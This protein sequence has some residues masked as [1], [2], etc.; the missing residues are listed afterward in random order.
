MLEEHLLTV[1]KDAAPEGLALGY[2]RTSQRERQARATTDAC[3]VLAR[4][5][6]SQ[7][8]DINQNLEDS[9]AL[10]EERSSERRPR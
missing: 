10:V 4:G 9:Q 3:R 6:T 2:K 5:T 7:I 1:L 8:T